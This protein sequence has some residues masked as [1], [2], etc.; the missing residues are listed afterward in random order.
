MKSTSVMLVLLATLDPDA[1]G[2]LAS[3]PKIK[4]KKS[5]FVSC[6]KKLRHAV[7]GTEIN[8]EMVTFILL[9]LEA[10]IP[11]QIE[12]YICGKVAQWNQM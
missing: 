9:S 7:K 2:N 11:S 1:K 5:S 12:N 10:V 4:F 6:G 8:T 3:F